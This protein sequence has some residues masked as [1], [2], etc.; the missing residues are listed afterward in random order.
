MVYKTS[1]VTKGH[2]YEWTKNWGCS[3]N[4]IVFREVLNINMWCI[5]TFTKIL[6]FWLLIAFKNCSTKFNSLLNLFT[7]NLNF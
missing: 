5:K 6:F 2:G 3:N 4:G 7:E 1:S